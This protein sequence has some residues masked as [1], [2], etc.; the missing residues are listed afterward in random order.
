MDNSILTAKLAEELGGQDLAPG[1]VE[2]ILLDVRQF[3]EY[4]RGSTGEYLDPEHLAVTTIDLAEWKGFLHRRGAKA[5]TLHRKFSSLRKM[6]LVLAP[7]LMGQLR[8]PRLP[9]VTNLSP[10]GFTRKELNAIVRAAAQLSSRDACIIHLA[11]WTGARVASLASVKLSNIE[12]NPRS[13]SVEFDVA[14]GGHGYRTPLN[15]MARDAIARWIAER[16][17]AANHPYLFCSER[18]PFK[19]LSSW[20]LHNVWHRRLAR[21]VPQELAKKLKGTHQARHNL[22]RTALEQGTP[23]PEIAALLNHKSVATT[24]NVYMRPSERDLQKAVDRLVG[25]ESEE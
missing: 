3:E 1:S 4:Y 11:L 18:W 10:S 13:G 6:V 25:D 24:A 22:A 16:P 15:S 7:G 2:R 21:H 9:R 8:W 12:L 5:A 17:A 23:L 19:P 20:A 14:K